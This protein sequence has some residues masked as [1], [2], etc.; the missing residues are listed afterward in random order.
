MLKLLK[1]LIGILL[2]VVFACTSREERMEYDDISLFNGA[3][4]ITDGSL[5]PAS[6]SLFYLD[7]PSPIF[8]KTFQPGQKLEKAILYITAAGYYRASING[9]HIGKNVLDPAWTEYSK[10]IYYTTYDVTSFIKEDA[11]CLGLT[12]GN[13]FYNP[14]P[15]RKWGHRNLREDLTVGKPAFIAKLIMHYQNGKT[16]EIVSDTTWKYAYGPIIKNSVYLGVTYDA[17]KEIKG[18]NMPA[19]NDALWA[20]ANLGK[21]PG[22]N[23]QKSFFPPVQLT[24]AITP[25]AI[26]SS[27]PGIY[28]VDMGVNFTGTYKIKLSG[29]PGDTILFRFG[30]R[31]YEDGNLNPM[32]S[33]IGQIK[34]KGMGGPGAPDIAWQADH[35]IIDEDTNA[36]FTPDFTYHTY[37][38]MEITGLDKKPQLSDIQGL[39]IHSNVVNKNSFSCSSELLNSIQT[40]TERTFLANLV[41]VQSDCPAREKFG[42]GGDINATSESFICNFDMQAFYRKTVYD[43]VDAMNDT[44]FV[45]TAPFVGIQYCGLSW[46]SAFLIT[47]YYLYLYYHDTAIIKELYDLDVQW[48]NKVEHIHPAGL[49]DKGLSDHESLE[50]V[51]VQLTGTCHYLQCARIMKK[52]AT[53]MEDDANKLKYETLAEKLKN[54]V[55]AEFWDQPRKEKINRQTLFSTL[56]YH[57]IVPE[58]EMD[59]ARDSL[60]KAVQNGPASHFNTGIF[61]TKYILE[62]TSEHIDPNAVYDIVNSTIYPGWGF[63]IDNGATTIW[64]TWKESDNTYS[65]CHPMFG[66]ITEWFYRWL[67]G[68][69]PDPDHPGFKEFVLAPST[70]EGLDYVDCIYHSPFGQIRST[71]KKMPSGDIQYKM[72]I[73]EGS[74]ANVQIPL[75]QTQKVLLQKEGSHLAS[76]KIDGEETGRFKLEAGAYLIAVSSKN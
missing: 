71:W 60:I 68:I 46:E 51:P 24:Q 69:R 36:W 8:R 37:R 6:D 47:Q 22:G 35:Y 26:T 48:M 23:L 39:F 7:H 4:W 21:N 14:L 65:N 73:P 5:L 75:N 40:A 74:M 31:L 64:E 50:P 34:R 41:S 30:E 28:M 66:T 44:G 13:G 32:T 3:N 17:R 2:F 16:E 1:L 33:V 49:V 38:Y 11:N 12:L 43:W 63:M 10:R 42:Y 67:G 27:E 25:L 58:E 29:N 20:N 57:G 59:A 76:E 61:G 70:P 72:T 53:V 54:Q 18:W 62:T 9:S 56:L 45:D 55:K 19:F 15:L 52:F